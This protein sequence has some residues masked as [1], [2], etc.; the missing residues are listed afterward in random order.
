MIIDPKTPYTNAQNLL[1]DWLD[2]EGDHQL[3]YREMVA[4]YGESET[5]KLFELAVYER[6]SGEEMDAYVFGMT[7]ELLRSV[8]VIKTRKV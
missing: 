6:Y 3:W 5:I 4:A 7:D 1:N 8:G 2:P